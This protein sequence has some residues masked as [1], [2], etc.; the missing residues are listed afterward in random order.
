MIV[1]VDLEH[2]R[3]QQ[4]DPERGQRTYANR[5]RVKYRLE[6]M[7]GEPC[8]LMRYNHVTPARLRDLRVKALFVSGNSTEFEHYAEADMAG[9][10]AVFRE[11]AYPTI[12]FCG[13][14]QILAQSYGAEIGPIG[15]LP[16]GVIDPTADERLAPGMI[17]ERGFMPVTVVN[18]HPLFAGLGPAPVFLESH[19]WEVKALPSGFRLYASTEKCKL[20]MIAHESRPL[21]A[22]QFHPE[23]YDETHQDGQKLIANFCRLYL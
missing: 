19:Y 18:D 13:G 15:V 1:I 14:C 5:L 11:A 21:I 23:F 20:Q 8:L 4:E 22:T 3:L 17:Q 10:R 16:V 12:A 7:A 2:A 6:D 9:L